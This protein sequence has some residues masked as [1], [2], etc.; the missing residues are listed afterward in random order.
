MPVRPTAGID[1]LRLVPDGVVRYAGMQAGLWGELGVADERAHR[2]LVRVQG[3][4]GPD[5]VF[6]AVLGGGRG[7]AERARLVP[8]G[9]E[10]TPARPSQDVPGGAGK[11]TSMPPWPGQL[12]A[13]APATV[14]TEPV[15]LLVHT[16]DGQLLTVDD[17]HALS[18][19]PANVHI[20]RNGVNGG[21]VVTAGPGRWEAAVA[22]TGWAGPWPAEERWWAPDEA[23]RLI[24]LQLALADGR[25][26]LVALRGRP[27]DHRSALRLTTQDD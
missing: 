21:P 1:R 27:V 7:Y 6:T 22:V 24:R 11:G 17:R 18:G 5:S 4:L 9:D 20:G 12:P 13:P 19:I 16:A 26:L 23:S 14:L 10:R 25:A 8:W 3:L 2:A 15:A